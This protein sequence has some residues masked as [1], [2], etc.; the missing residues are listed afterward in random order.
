MMM[1]A[2]S[3]SATCVQADAAQRGMPDV[4]TTVTVL[5]EHSFTCI[6]LKR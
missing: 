1:A 2:G 4:S 5:H 6:N 3:R